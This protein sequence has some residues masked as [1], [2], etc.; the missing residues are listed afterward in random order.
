ME[1][2]FGVTVLD[3]TREAGAYAS[4]LFADL[5]AEVIRIEPPEGSPIRKKA[6]FFQNEV[7][8]ETSFQHLYFNTNKKSIVLDITKGQGQAAVKDLICKADIL[9]EDYSPGSLE[10]YGLDYNQLSTRNPK[11]VYTS[12]TPFGQSGPYADFLA[13]D[14]TLLAMG[15]LMYLGGEPERS[16]VRA[17]GE[18][19]YFAASLYGAVGTMIAFYHAE[20]TGEGQHVDVSMQECVAMAMENAAQ[21]YDLQGTIRK[22]KGMEQVEAAWGTYPCKDGFIYLLIG[23]FG[24][25]YWD[26]L[27]KWLEDE[28]NEHAAEFLNPRWKEHEWR[29]SDEGKQLFNKIFVPFAGNFTKLEFYEEAQR[30]NIAICPVNEPKDLFEN[31]QLQYREF[32]QKLANEE[33]EMIYPGPPYRLS[34]TPWKLKNSAPRLGEHTEELLIQTYSPHKL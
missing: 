2:L 12:I 11:L 20:V 1:A 15:G 19:A 24:E 34:L 10:E 21:F 32:F 18:Q 6:P 25:R 3:L 27:Q 4:K 9:I 33:N 23:G 16:P 8:L 28:E 31:P 26:Y 30:R 22:R 29:Q 7:N 13:T 14:L 5:G 17:Y